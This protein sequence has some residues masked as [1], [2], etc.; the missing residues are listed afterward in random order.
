MATIG[1]GVLYGYANGNTSYG[2]YDLYMD[3]DYA[4]RSGT[5]IYFH[6]VRVRG[7]QRGSGYTTNTVYLD[8][9][10]INGVNIGLSWSGKGSSYSSWATG[11][12]YPTIGGIGGGTGSLWVQLWC[13]RTGQDWGVQ[14]PGG[15]V[16]IPTAY[17]PSLSG[18]TVTS[19][20]DT[21]ARLYFSVTND[22]GQGVTDS[23]IDLSLSNFGTV[24][25]SAG[26]RDNTFTGLE[27][28]TTYY[29]RGNAA[30]AMGRSYTGV[31][32]FKTSFINPG[33]PSGVTNSFDKPE[34]IPL[35]KITGTWKA[36]SAGSK[37]VAGYRV[38]LF[39]GTTELAMVDTESTALSYQFPNTL[40]SYGVN[41]GDIVRIGVYAYS[42]DAYGNKFFNGG[43]SGEAQVFS[44]YVTIVSDKYIYASLNGAAFNK[45]KMYCS[46][47]GGAFVEV[48]KEKFKVIK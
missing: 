5:N 16:Y 45:Y 13:H 32:S 33:G 23:Y 36:G 19:V 21:S 18:L 26:N 28:N 15:T 38:R 27:P 34:P 31:A 11:Y 20:G 14:T 41:V 42:K 6:A 9:V 1:V 2:C 3:Y 48:K 44:S 4:S 10:A 47:N 17:P 43:G 7:V 12:V 46:N 37:P 29:G 8:Q 40:E 35:S 39:K 25:K 24:V 30:N 22:N